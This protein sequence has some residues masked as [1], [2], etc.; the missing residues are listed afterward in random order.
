MKHLRK[1]SL[2]LV[3]LMAALLLSAC[4]T[5]SD[6]WPVSNGGVQPQQ[7]DVPADAPAAVQTD[8]QSPM[9]THDQPAQPGGSEEP[10]LNG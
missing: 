2:L 1:A 7:T 8:A 6:P 3:C 9:P 4:H 5:E 10:G